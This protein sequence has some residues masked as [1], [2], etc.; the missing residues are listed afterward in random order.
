MKIKPYIS[1]I[2]SRTRTQLTRKQLRFHFENRTGKTVPRDVNLRTYVAE[3]Y[4][5]QQAINGGEK[6]SRFW[7]SV[8]GAP[9]PYLQ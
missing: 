7:C 1:E 2:I 5:H 9:F 3:W 4:G 8:V 6:P